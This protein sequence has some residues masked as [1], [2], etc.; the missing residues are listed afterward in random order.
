MGGGSDGPTGFAVSR[1]TAISGSDTEIPPSAPRRLRGPLCHE[2]ESFTAPRG[3]PLRRVTDVTA[4]Q[5]CLPRMVRMPESFRGVAPSARSAGGEASLPSEINGYWIVQQ[6][7]PLWYVVSGRHRHAGAATVILACG[8]DERKKQPRVGV[9]LRMPLHRDA[10]RVIGLLQRF[11]R[12][13]V[14]ESSCLKPGMV[15]HGLMM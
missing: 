4:F 2:P 11:N 5:S 8:G 9:R 6:F 7:C 1:V 12:A 15:G 13:V 3:L 10:E 14:R